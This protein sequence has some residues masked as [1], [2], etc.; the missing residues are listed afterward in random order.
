MKARFLILTILA[1]FS[2]PACKTIPSSSLVYGSTHSFGVGLGKDASGE[3]LPDFNIGYKSRD[4]ARVPVAVHIDKENPDDLK[5]IWGSHCGGNAQEKSS[6]SDLF[7]DKPKLTA[8]E[9]EIKRISGLELS[10]V[11]NILDN[12]AMEAEAQEVVGTNSL[13]LFAFDGSSGPGEFEESLR[14]N[15]ENAIRANLKSTQSIQ[16]DAED[17]STAKPGD[18]PERNAAAAI[19]KGID[20]SVDL[21]RKDAFSV[22]G[23]FNGNA[24]STSATFG[25]IFATGVA[26]QAVASSLDSRSRCVSSASTIDGIT[27]EKIKELCN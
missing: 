24:T 4:F 17:L 21:V 27:F 11:R 8:N 20:R 5:L 18:D 9:S 19:E 1:A 23:S 14:R 2:L 26:A 22:F 3:P 16:G 15:L 10:D 7:T 12:A 25:R 13:R 6:C